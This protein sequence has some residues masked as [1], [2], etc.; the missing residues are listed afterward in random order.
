M[1]EPQRSGYAA[2]PQVHYWDASGAAHFQ[3]QQER[4]AQHLSLSTV[5]PG[6][7]PDEVLGEWL[8]HVWHE[9]GHRTRVVIEQRGH[10]DQVGCVRRVSG[11]VREQLLSVGRSSIPR[12]EAA[13][14]EESEEEYI[15]GSLSERRMKIASVEY[16]VIGG[17]LPVAR[18]FGFVQF[19]PLEPGETLIVW[20]FAFD[21]SPIGYACCCGGSFIKWMLRYAFEGILQDLR[22]HIVRTRARRNVNPSRR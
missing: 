3:H 9:G 17:P 6:V 15:S 12:R 13:D 18:F 4:C 19:I 21:P 14:E 7:T 20:E 1:S 5:V 2:E 8:S 11:G 10:D 16:Q 22:E